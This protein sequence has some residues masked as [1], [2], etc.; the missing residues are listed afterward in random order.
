[1]TTEKLSATKLARKHNTSVAAIQQQLVRLGYIEV[2]SG[3]HY[4]TELGRSIGGEW[5]QN[6]PKASFCDGYMVW[7]ANLPLAEQ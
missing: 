7:P 6:D 5:R 4:F 1:M 3:L 2:R